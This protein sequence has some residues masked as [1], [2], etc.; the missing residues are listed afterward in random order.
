MKQLASIIT[1]YVTGNF[2]APGEPP[3]SEP[4][5][6][7]VID[8]TGLAGDYDISLD[9]RQSRDWFVVLEQQLGLKLEAR[10]V[11]MEMLIIDSAVKPSAN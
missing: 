4:E 5:R 7:P 2:P 9:L 6:L 3:L 1:I 10:K 8:Q 11:P